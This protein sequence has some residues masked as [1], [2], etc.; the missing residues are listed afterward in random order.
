MSTPEWL[1]KC[2]IEWEH[3][4]YGE[5]ESWR[6]KLPGSKYDYAEVFQNDEGTWCC[7]AG[8]RVVSPREA[9]REEAFNALLVYLRLDVPK[10]AASIERQFLAELRAL[11]SKYG[12]ELEA[13]D[14][15]PGFAECG[16]DSRMTVTVPSKYDG[17]GNA[18][19]ERCEIDLGSHVDGDS[20]YKS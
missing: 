7:L 18:T 6:G 17:D 5:S 8:S 12:A 19:R 4:T 15:Y 13:E 14:H 20:P 9:T 3:G 16:S 10:D 1:N 2:G 11:L